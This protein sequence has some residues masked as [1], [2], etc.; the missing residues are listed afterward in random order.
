MKSIRKHLSIALGIL[1]LLLVFGLVGTQDLKDD[2]KAASYTAEIMK[3]AKEEALTNR[4]SEWIT[5]VDQAEQFTPP[6][7]PSI[8]LK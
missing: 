5:L 2:E 6:K 4:K 1:A 7:A 3:S 8:A